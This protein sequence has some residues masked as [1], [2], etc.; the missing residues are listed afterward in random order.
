M[1]K[2]LSYIVSL[3]GLF[4]AAAFRIMPSLTRIMNS[5]QFLI[6]NQVAVD[7]IYKE[8]NV[9]K[10]KNGIKN[11]I[12]IHNIWNISELSNYAY[13]VFSSKQPFLNC[14]TRISTSKN[15]FLSKKERQNGDYY[16]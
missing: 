11:A 16:L 1:G 6:Y 14:K 13:F 3:L 4:A 9:E 8:F 5:L 15:E 7:S 12:F 2:E 10:V